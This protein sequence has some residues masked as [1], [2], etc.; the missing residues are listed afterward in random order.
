MRTETGTPLQDYNTKS[1]TSR[2]PYLLGLLGLIP[3][4][5]F[6]VGVGLILYGA[7]KYKDR[8]LIIIGVACVLFTIIVYTGL[9][10]FG[11]RSEFGKRGWAKHSQMQLNTLIK[12][13]EFYKLE[14][15]KYPDSLKQL[16]TDKEF[17]SLTDPTQSFGTYYNYKKLGEKYLLFSS[18]IDRIPNTTDDIYPEVNSANDKIGWHRPN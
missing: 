17:I 3:L 5:G 13:I 14:N 15:G 7:I 2:P 6:F 10:H 11:F 16:E 12:H 8:K 4:V 18:G 1:A 9:F